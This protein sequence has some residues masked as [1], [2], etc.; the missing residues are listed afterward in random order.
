[1]IRNAL[2]LMSA[3][4]AFGCFI[5]YGWD[6]F[7]GR[8]K[9]ARSTRLMFALLLVLALLQQHE[10][11]SR[12]SLALT[13]GES[14]GAIG[15]LAL[16]MW[17]GVGGL[18]RLDL[19]CYVLLIV[20]VIIWQTSHNGLLGLHLTILGDQ[21]AIWPTLV[22]TWRHPKSETPFFFIAGSVAPLFAIASEKALSYS[23]VLYPLY[24]MLINTVMVLLI[25][26]HNLTPGDVIL[27]E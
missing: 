1:M 25:Y 15:I 4:I 22:K 5:P 8:A 26:R 27:A 3:V 10:I 21:I 7:R 20:D 17:K 11:G 12:L 9:P 19:V 14:L 16:A 24:L 18:K 2:S 23:I 13:A 6:V